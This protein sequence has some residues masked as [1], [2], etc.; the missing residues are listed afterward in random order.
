MARGL[1]A[2]GDVQG[3]KVVPTNKNKR[4]RDGTSNARV[5][6][7]RKRRK[8]TNSIE[9]V[10]DKESDCQKAIVDEK[11]IKE[12]RIKFHPQKFCPRR[13][14]NVP[15]EHQT[16][17]NHIQ[18][19]GQM[20]YDSYALQPRPDI[21]DKPWELDNKLRAKRVTQKAAQART[22]YQ[23]EDGWRM[24]LENRVF[25]RFE[26]EVA[27][28]GTGLSDI[29]TTRIGERSVIQDDPE[30]YHQIA[31]KPDRIYGL[32]TT[33]AIDKILQQ[34]RNSHLGE[35]PELE[36][37]LL[38]RLTISCNPDSGGRA[39]IYPFLVMEAKSLKGGSNFQKIENQTAVP[40]RNHLSLQLKLQEDGFNRMQNIILLWEG[41]ITGDDEA[42][43]LVLIVDYIVDW[44]RDIYRPS[45]IR[46]LM[47]VVDRGSRSSYTIIEEPDILSIPGYANSWH[48]GRPVAT[49]AGAE[50][51]VPAEPAFDAMDSTIE[52]SLEPLFESTGKHVDIRVWDGAK[53]ESRVRGLYIT[54][55]D[56]DVV[57][58]FKRTGYY[59]IKTVHIRR[60]WF[61][62]SCPQD[63]KAIEEAWTGSQEIKD[64]QNLSSQ[65]ILISLY[66]QYRTNYDGAPIRELT[67]LAL[68]ESVASGFFYPERGVGRNEVVSAEELGLKLREAWTSSNENYFHRYASGQTSVLCVT[69]SDFDRLSDRI[70][71][72]FRDDSEIMP[73]AR[74][75]DSFIKKS[76]VN[77][78]SGLHK[79]Y[80]KCLRYTKA[81][82]SLTVAPHCISDP[83]QA[84][85]FINT[86]DV[87]RGICVYVTNAA[88]EEVNHAWIIRHLVQMVL[89]RWDCKLPYINPPFHP[90]HRHDESKILLWIVSDPQWDLYVAIK[91]TL[92]M[93]RM[94]RVHKHLAWFRKVLLR[95]K[96]ETGI[97]WGM[98]YKR[99]YRNVQSDIQDACKNCDVHKFCL[100]SSSSK[101]DFCDEDFMLE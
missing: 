58:N 21:I 12:F 79:L 30:N 33:D 80:A 4:K 87:F 65:R 32:R 66:V 49:I 3:L 62:L 7:A 74:R 68:A 18:Q 55:D 73:F 8:G 27:C 90:D 22:A 44:A 94:N 99:G 64:V 59:R 25:E 89:V 72:S 63:I 52:S 42:L 77:P 20:K 97:H 67:Y 93:P 78:R 92:T 40:I 82:H 13:P 56:A 86:E 95:H 41:S 11:I 47:S 54:G 81:V 75:L 98:A 84:C 100:T 1:R 37:V 6:L 43:Q 85:V 60:C 101:Y 83:T 38:N 71:L 10:P 14:G 70:V 35:D 2:R 48:G 50:T 88:S 91:S 26:I 34:P 28:L 69:V 46:Q 15:K 24:E 16:K 39:A 76:C 31:M 96:C 9:A 51:T 57:K 5:S 36:D 17:F 19:L 61:L 45:I 23:N 53:Y 29:F